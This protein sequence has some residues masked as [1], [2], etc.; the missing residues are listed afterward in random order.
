MTHQEIVGSKPVWGLYGQDA[1]DGSMTFLDRVMCCGVADEYQYDDYAGW[2]DVRR[3]GSCHDFCFWM[4]VDGTAYNPTYEAGS[5]PWHTPVAYDNNGAI[6]AFFTCNLSGSG[7]GELSTGLDF[8]ENDSGVNSFPYQK[9]GF[10]GQHTHD[11]RQEE[12]MG[13]FRT[14]NPQA[15]PELVGE[16]QPFTFSKCADAC[17]SRNYHYFGRMGNGQCRCGGRTRDDYTFKRYGLIPYGSS[18]YCKC[19]ADNIGNAGMCTYRVVDQFDPNTARK[20]HPCRYLPAQDMRKM[21]YIACR[22]GNKN[23]ANKL[24]CKLMETMGRTYLSKM[25]NKHY[26]KG[27]KQLHMLG[28]DVATATTLGTF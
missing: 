19:D 22:D 11:Y 16:G 24:T 12:Y 28:G 15:L 17:A 5:N 21:C 9:C 23:M 1:W 18:D 2:Y 8:L 26:D 7:S 13:C 4:S 10:E 20:N 25:I 14:G 6:K 3:C 27:G